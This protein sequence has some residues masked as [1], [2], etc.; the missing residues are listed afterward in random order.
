VIAPGSLQTVEP[1]T[2]IDRHELYWQ[3]GASQG[4]IAALKAK[5]LT[6]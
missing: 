5:T 6:G 4:D 3:L 2:Q 1:G